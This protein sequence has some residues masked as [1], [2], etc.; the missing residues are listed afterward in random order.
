MFTNFVSHMLTCLCD[1]MITCSCVQMLWWTHAPMFTCFDDY[2][3]PCLHVLTIKYTLACMPIWLISLD[4]LMI[5]C[6]HSCMS[7]YLRV[8]TCLVTHMST[9]FDY[10]MLSCSH[11]WLLTC[12]NAYMF[13]CL[14]AY[15]LRWSYAPM[16]ICLDDH[17]LL[18]PYALMI[19][20][21]LAY[22]LWWSYVLILI[23]FDDH[24]LLCS[25]ALIFTCLISTHMCTHLDMFL[26][27]EVE[28]IL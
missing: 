25:H 3:L 17:M 19:A 5:T 20:F 24:M 9:W 7:S 8:L 26:C 16:L 12:L 4:A 18:C 27:L 14:H 6:S 2:T 28:L 13:E 15:M 23:C 22:I 11:A 10:C 21:S 1:L